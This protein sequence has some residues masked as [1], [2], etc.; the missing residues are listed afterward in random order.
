M[1]FKKV[2]EWSQIWGDEIARRKF[3]LKGGRCFRL[4]FKWVA[5]KLAGEDFFRFRK[6]PFSDSEDAL[7]Q[8]KAYKAGAVVSAGWRGPDKQEQTVKLVGETD[9]D[10][11]V[12][13]AYEDLVRNPWKSA[14][15]AF[16]YKQAITANKAA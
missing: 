11:D 12:R 10:Y 16:A 14:A 8:E 4:S 7:K 3:G 6:W 5:L 9:W 1:A 2:R 13:P 15:K